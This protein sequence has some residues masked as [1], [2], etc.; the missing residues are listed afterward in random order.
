M[1]LSH[2]EYANMHFVYGFCNAT[3]AVEEYRQRY[4]HRRIP[5]RHGFTRVR[6]FLGGKGSFPSVKRRAKPQVQRSVEEKGNVIDMLQ[7]SPR[8]STKRIS[9]RL[10]FLLMSV[11]NYMYGDWLHPNHIQRVQHLERAVMGIR[12]QCCGLNN[13]NLRRIRNNLCADEVH[14]PHDRFNNI[15]KSHL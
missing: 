1:P 3:D 7:R 2:E 9:G 15:K 4:T 6:Q 13:N 10:I 8:S 12:R 11:E 5:D 14:F